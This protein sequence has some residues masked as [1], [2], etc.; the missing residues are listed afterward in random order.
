M[1]NLLCACGSPTRECAFWKDVLTRTLGDIDRVDGRALADLMRRIERRV[2]P[3]SLGFPSKI[4][5]RRHP[6]F[7]EYRSVIVRLY[8]SIAEVAKAVFVVDSSKHPARAT[9]LASADKL[10]VYLVHLVRDC[11]GVAW[12]W[13]RNR[14]RPEIRATETLMD[15]HGTTRCIGHWL[16]YNRMIRSLRQKVSKYLVVRYED[17]VTAPTVELERIMHWL[18]VTGVDLSFIQKDEVNLGRDHT[19][20]GNPMRFQSGHLRVKMDDE[21]KGKLGFLDRLSITA[22][23]WPLLLRYGYSIKP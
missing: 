12:S 19:I 18:G 23:T 21:W 1:R 4:V 13:K 11:R 20:A 22:A 9:L 10:D 7:E 8:K 15:R 17:L 6:R 5:R 16:G 14:I 3:V 2:T